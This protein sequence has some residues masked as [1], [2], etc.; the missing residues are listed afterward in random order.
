M[1]RILKFLSVMLVSLFALVQL[2][3]C[4]Y[5]FYDDWHE[6]GAVIEKENVFT[7][8]NL[9]EA[10]KKID[11]DETF[12]LVIGCSKS[13]TAVSQISSIQEQADYHSFKGTIYFLDATAYYASSTSRKDV[14]SKLGVKT[15]AGV[16]NSSLVIAVYNKGELL[17]D[18][19]LKK[20]CRM[21]LVFVSQEVELFDLSIRDNLCLGKE[22]SEEKIMQL[23]D[24][25]GLM[26]WYKELPNG[27]ETM[28]GEKGINKIK[29]IVK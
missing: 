12:V 16:D 21:D 9:D 17:V 28:V 26:N 18:N 25:A 22:V 24:E 2:T 7:S 1:K 13:S 23:I 27:L 4:A 14:Q 6:A 5:S 20:D 10:V 15:I 11:N 29:N 3:G 19:Q 8:I